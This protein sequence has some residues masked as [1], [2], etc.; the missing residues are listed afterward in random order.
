[1]ILRCFMTVILGCSGLQAA[2]FPKEKSF[3]NSIGMEFV[4]IEPGVFRMGND[5]RL[6]DA[7]LK[8]TE[9]DGKRAV[10]LPEK[11]DYDERP[12]HKVNITKPFYLGVLEVSNTQ[13]ERF[14]PRHAHLRGKLGFSIDDQEAVVFIS[15]QEAKAFCS[16]LSKKEGLP[17]RLPT[18]A[19]WEY[20]AR[21]GTTTAFSTGELL[22]AAYLNKPDNS[23]YPA[24]GRSQ[25]RDSLA[26]LHVG[27]T[28]ANPWGLRDMHGNVEEW[29]EDWYGPYLPED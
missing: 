18:E 2:D 16:W 11:G 27:R 8:V 3:T 9:S 14:D 23:W 24:P 28:P 17:Y 7:V 12:V 15:W 1:M 19:E 5:N 13:F 22:P 29:C 25:G 4:R 6:E 21:A 26:L 10:W 20:A